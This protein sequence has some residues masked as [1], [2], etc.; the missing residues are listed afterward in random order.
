MVGQMQLMGDRLQ[1]VIN[2]SDHTTDTVPLSQ[3]HG[4]ITMGLL[5]ITMVTGFPTVLVGFD[6]FKVGLTLPQLIQGCLLG[7]IILMI[8]GIPATFM[9]SNTGQS[10]SLL[11]RTVFGAWGSRLVSTNLIWVNIGW[12]GLS[13]AFLAEGLQGIYHLPIPTVALATFLTFPMAFNNYFGFTGIANFARYLAAP[14]LIAWVGYTFIKAGSACSPLVFNSVAHVTTAQAVT[15]VT[16]L[17]VGFGVWGNE[18]D[19]WRYGKPQKRLSAVPLFVSLLIGQFIFPITGWMMAN[20]SGITEIAAATNLMNQYAFGGISIIAATVLVVSY[21]ATTDSGIYGSMTAVEN[22]VCLPR[23]TVVTG[24]AIAGAAA[25]VFLCG[26][27]RAFE[28][29][30]VSS[31]IIIPSAMV[32]MMVEYYWFSRKSGLQFNAVPKFDT[33]P[34]LRFSAI[35]ALLAAYG[36]GFATS[37]LI[38]GLELLHIGVSSMTAWIT[39]IVV[40][41]VLRTLELRKQRKKHDAQGT[42]QAVR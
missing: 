22:L 33:L 13:A 8:Y 3:R 6:A 25:A 15:M 26:N 19:F 27:A 32:I 39:A 5:W 16:A 29:V 35:A 40:Y 34:P 18:A 38:P 28:L 41:S 42:P 31:S 14:I 1:A 23:K 37:G 21:F 10:Y 2:E 20:M 9:G 24:L 12:Y 36:T 17:V 7:C 11:S 4:P 30:A